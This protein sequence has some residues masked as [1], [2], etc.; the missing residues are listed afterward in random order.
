MKKIK[1]SFDAWIQ[2]LGMA[3]VLG[4]LVFV[5]LKMQQSQRVALPNTQQERTNTAIANFDA[6]TSAGVDWQSFMLENNLNYEYS[7]DLIARRNT[8][9]MSWFF[10]ENDH[11]QYTQGLVDEPV[12]EAKKKAFQDWYNRCDLR[13]LYEA[14]SRYMPDGFTN[15]IETLPDECAKE[16]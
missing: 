14:R 9:H 15:L 4:G 6:W 10:F 7:K 8:Y 3:G 12:W 11:F 16:Q 13:S 2:L 1:V 5:G